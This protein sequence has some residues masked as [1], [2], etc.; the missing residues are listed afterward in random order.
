MRAEVEVMPVD[1]Y[2]SWVQRRGSPAGKAR[3]RQG[4]VHGRLRQVPRPLPAK[5]DI[6]PSIALEP[7]ARQRN[8]SRGD[9]PQRHGQDARRRQGLAAGELDSTITYLKHKFHVG[10][11]SGG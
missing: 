7:T 9:H 8:R 5:G 10:G 4:G 3:A 1:E 6:G 11:S 2:R